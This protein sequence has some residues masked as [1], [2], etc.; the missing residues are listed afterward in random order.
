MPAPPTERPSRTPASTGTGMA[1]R[2]R[3]RHEQQAQALTTVLDVD[4]N[5]NANANADDDSSTTNIPTEEQHDSVH[6]SPPHHHPPA[7]QETV[8]DDLHLRDSDEAE[9][10]QQ[11]EDE[12]RQEPKQLDTTR[13]QEKR[14]P[15]EP[16]REPP[17]YWYVDDLPKAAEGRDSKAADST[18]PPERATAEE[19]AIL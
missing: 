11:S 17:W 3:L 4:A 8:D 6:A 10:A 12:F 15:P 9:G 5:A 2:L 13:E 1:A 18:G 19:E 7:P 14:H 16:E